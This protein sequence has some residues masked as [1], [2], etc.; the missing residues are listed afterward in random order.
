[1]TRNDLDFETWFDLLR[2]M[3][4]ED[5]I[6]FRDA[7]AAREDYDDGKDLYDVIDEIRA[8]YE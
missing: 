4:A 2:D 3:L 7:D 8:E 1:M 6:H 5:G